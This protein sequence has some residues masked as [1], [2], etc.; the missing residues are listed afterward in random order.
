[1]SNRL[2]VEPGAKRLRLVESE[3]T[4]LRRGIINGLV[5]ALPFW[6]AIGWLV[7]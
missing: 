1:M 7:F 4:R 2:L 3:A 6:A 5:M